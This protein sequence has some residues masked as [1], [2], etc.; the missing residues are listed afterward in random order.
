VKSPSDGWAASRPNVS[1][2]VSLNCT[3]NPGRA[4]SMGKFQF[5]FYPQASEAKAFRAAM[6]AAYDRLNPGHRFVSP[7]PG[8][9]P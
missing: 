8:E 9:T 5:G 4:D 7:G 3:I 6:V 1:V 2:N